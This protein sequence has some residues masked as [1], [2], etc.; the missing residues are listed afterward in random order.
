[1]LT[2]DIDYSSCLYYTCTVTC[3][4]CNSECVLSLADIKEMNEWMNEWMNNNFYLY[5]FPQVFQGKSVSPKFIICVQ[6]R[7]S[8]GRESR[9]CSQCADT[10][11]RRQCSRPCGHVSQRASTLGGPSTNAIFHTSREDYERTVLFEWPVVFYED[12]SLRFNF[13]IDL[14]IP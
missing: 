7:R 11:D 13:P 6:W 3:F 1:M 5:F 8:S 10:V 12:S 2:Q 9:Q 14:A 4:H